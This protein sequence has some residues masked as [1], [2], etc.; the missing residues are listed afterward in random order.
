MTIQAIETRYAGCRFR[1]RLEARWAVFFDTLGVKWEYE[2]QGYHV[3]LTGDGD[4]GWP[5]QGRMYLPDFY[6]PTTQ[7]WVEVKGDINTFDWQLMAEA[8][9]WG[10]GLPGTANSSD[11]LRGLL[12]LGPIPRLGQNRPAH[13]ILQHHKGG[14]VSYAGF[15]ASAPHLKVITLHEDH[16][17]SSWGRQDEESWT[18][19]VAQFWIKD[20]VFKNDCLR[21]IDPVV[22]A[23]RAARSARFEHGEAGG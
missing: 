10:C 19:R 14:W 4:D 11:T 9:D 21:P 6:L 12:L 17:D 1:S 7:T 2:P 15:V 3:G 8:V 16:F 22:T 20:P 5:E 18:N 13:P 23:Y